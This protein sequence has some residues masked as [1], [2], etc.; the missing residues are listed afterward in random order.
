MAKFVYGNDLIAALTNILKEAKSE[1]YLIS[2]YIKLHSRFK[3]ELKKKMDMPEL[4]ITIVFGKN[5][6]DLRKSL[7]PEDLAFLIQLPNI[8]ICYEPRLH[9]KYYA[10]EA[11][12]LITSMNLYDFSQNNNIES[13]V[14]TKR[15]F[16]GGALDNEASDYFVNEVA[17]HCEVIFEKSP[18]DD[19][20]DEDSEILVD[21][22]EQYFGSG[23]SSKKNTTP[24]SKSDF[25]N[26]SQ[27]APSGKD[28]FGYCIR[29][30]VPIPFNVEKPFCPEAYQRWAKYADVNYGE[31]FCHFSG[32]ISDGTITFAKPILKKNWKAAKATHGL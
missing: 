24:R 2:P 18:V 5:E 29:T 11:A 22:L 20:P 27:S 15:S 7:Y 8:K 9:A 13:G 14:L 19:E 28:K 12:G 6:D 32:E 26:I 31:K 10:N 3:D 17:E 23:F 21:K 4:E 25:A 16:F 30:G 1:L